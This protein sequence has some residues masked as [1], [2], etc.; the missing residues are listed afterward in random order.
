[1]FWR[2][3]IEREAPRRLQGFENERRN[4][5]VRRRARTITDANTV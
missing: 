1:M 2:E 4:D 5:T 3:D